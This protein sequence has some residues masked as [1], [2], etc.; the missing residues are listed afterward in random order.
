MESCGKQPFY[1]PKEP[2]WNHTLLYPER[3]RT[4]QN[5]ATAFCNAAV[6]AERL[7][8]ASDYVDRMNSINSPA[9]QAA[10]LLSLMPLLV[11]EVVRNNP[12]LRGTIR[13][14]VV[15]CLLTHGV[16]RG[17]THLQGSVERP[18]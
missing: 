10:T 5:E 16:V 18:F 6:Y 8:S 4:N 9:P 17:P 3:T 13:A 15:T 12:T 14:P 2:E 1:N 11:C 7:F